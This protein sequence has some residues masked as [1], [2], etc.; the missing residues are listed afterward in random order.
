MEDHQDDERV[1]E[2]DLWKKGEGFGFVQPQDGRA[3]GNQIPVFL[4]LF[5]NAMKKNVH[6][7]E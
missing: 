2:R 3:Q 5:Y 4:G 6:N 1:G 7:Q